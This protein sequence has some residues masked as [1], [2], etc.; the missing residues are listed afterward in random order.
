M[1]FMRLGTVLLFLHCSFAYAQIA[2]ECNVYSPGYV[3]SGNWAASFNIHSPEKEMLIRSDCLSSS[4]IDF[5]RITDVT[6][7]DGTSDQLIWGT[8]YYWDEPETEWV[9]FRV[10]SSVDGSN[11][12]GD[13][14]Y[15]LLNTF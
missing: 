4:L 12:C 2:D 8:A 10:C 3:T 15:P 5:H 1:K 6:L 13:G 7:G 9:P 14:R 11:W